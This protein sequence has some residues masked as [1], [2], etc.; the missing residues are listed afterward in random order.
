MNFVRTCAHFCFWTP[1]VSYAFSNLSTFIDVNPATELTCSTV[2][3]ACCSTWCAARIRL[4]YCSRTE[5]DGLR[6]VKPPK[7]AAS[8]EE[9]F[10]SYRPSGAGLFTGAPG[11]FSVETG[12]GPSFWA[13]GRALG[14]DGGARRLGTDPRAQ[15]S[16]R[17][18]PGSFRLK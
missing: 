2:H 11:L 10:S 4:A 14:L 13:R 12:S 15:G 7:A 16:L 5:D 18:H 3:P 8:K 9:L 17:A 1:T 6:S